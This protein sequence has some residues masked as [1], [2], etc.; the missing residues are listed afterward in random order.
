MATLVP[1]VD[2]PAQPTAPVQQSKVDNLDLPDTLPNGANRQMFDS[3]NDNVK[4]MVLS[5]LNGRMPSTGR[6]GM[7]KDFMTKLYLVGN[8]ID[9]N[10]DA[11]TFKTRQQTRTDYGAGGTT[12]K[13]RTSIMAAMAHL[14]NLEQNYMGLNNG[15]TP[16]I[17]EAEN[18]ALN[19]NLLGLGTKIGLGD[20][21]RNTQG[22]LA[23]ANRN[24][25]DLS[26]ELANAFRTGGGMS[27]ADITRELS[28][29]NVNQA[30]S[31]MKG[32]VTAAVQ[33]L[34]GKLQP[35]VDSYNQTM[36]T[37]LTVSDFLTEPKARAIYNRMESGGFGNVP[38]A[39][40]AQPSIAIPQ[41]A[42]ATLKLNPKLSADFDAKYGPGQSSKIL[43]SK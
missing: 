25:S 8:Q 3:L 29:L 15:D 38:K 10:F 40:T 36:G 12:G 19:S 2:T 20:K 26:G 18:N 42:I 34:H 41:G 7:D 14:G 21:V 23:G 6:N 32:Q 30:P 37:N 24:I 27:E 28:G 22:Y 35:M 1:W 4:P 17:N 9:P 43:G 16:W 31:A 33:D 5:L 39:T 13:K 11:T